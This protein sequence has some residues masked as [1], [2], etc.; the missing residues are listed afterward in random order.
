[1]RRKNGRPNKRWLHRV[2][3]DINDN[4]LSGRECTTELHAIGIRMM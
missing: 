4:G 2:R 3:G 1:M